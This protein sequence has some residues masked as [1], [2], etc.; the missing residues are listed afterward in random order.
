[1]GSIGHGTRFDKGPLNSMPIERDQ[2][3]RKRICDV[4]IIVRCEGC[5]VRCRLINR[6]RPEIMVERRR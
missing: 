5:C 1:M 4:Y 3:V 2:I 6:D